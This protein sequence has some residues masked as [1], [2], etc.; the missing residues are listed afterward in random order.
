MKTH[1]KKLQYRGFQLAE[2]VEQF[3]RHGF[4][5]WFHPLKQALVF[6]G[7]TVRSND[8]TKGNWMWQVFDVR[9]DGD[10][11]LIVCNHRTTYA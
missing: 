11:C 7:K 5:C 8:A 4:K 9:E 2:L 3:S 1:E 6:A 10:G